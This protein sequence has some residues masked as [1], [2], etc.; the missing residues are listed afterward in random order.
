[1]ML[2]E[3]KIGFGFRL[4]IFR[5]L[6]PNDVKWVTD[7]DLDSSILIKVCLLFLLHEE[8]DPDSYL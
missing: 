1:M 6:I 2:F 5:G 4:Q 7:P 8:K 3:V